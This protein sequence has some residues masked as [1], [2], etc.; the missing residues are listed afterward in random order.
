MLPPD[1]TAETFSVLDRENMDSQVQERSDVYNDIMSSNSL[2]DNVFKSTV[3]SGLASLKSELAEVKSDLRRVEQKQQVNN[4]PQC[5]VQSHPCLLYLCLSR[6]HDSPLGKNG[7]QILLGCAVEQYVLLKSDPT[8]TYQVKILQQH[9]QGALSN[10]QTSGCFIDLWRPRSSVSRSRGFEHEQS[11]VTK[12]VATPT[13]L[14]ITCW[15]CRGLSN[16]TQYLNELISDGSDIIE[17][18]TIQAVVS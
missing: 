17:L 13:S 2:S 11:Q 7:L 3:L 5:A 18:T 12:Q 10:T 15:N 9:L 16:S 6:P 1:D 8:A 4:Q 14:K